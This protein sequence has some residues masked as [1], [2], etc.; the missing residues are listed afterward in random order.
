MKSNSPKRKHEI[1]YIATIRFPTEKAHGLQIAKMCEAF[2]KSGANVSLLIPNRT[3]P[4]EMK[5]ATPFSY[6]S[7]KDKYTIIKLACVDLL[8]TSK[9]SLKYL[10]YLLLK[11]SFFLSLMFYLRTKKNKKTIV[12]TREII[13][14][15]LVRM[16]GY[17][18]IFLEIHDWPQ[19]MAGDFISKKLLKRVNGIVCVSPQLKKRVIISN[20]INNNHILLSPNAIDKIFLKTHKKSE[21]RKI[22]KLPLNKNIVMY[23][24]GLYRSKGINTF[25]K[26]SDFFKNQ[27][28]LFVVVGGSYVEV[29]EKSIIHRIKQKPN[30]VHF[31][32]QKHNKMP[33]FLSAA[34]ILVIPNSEKIKA[35]AYKEYT[36]PLK[37]YEFMSAGRP[38]ILSKVTALK[39]I[40]KN[41]HNT[42]FFKPDSAEDLANKIK[43]LF[44]NK[45]LQRSLSKNAK[46]VVGKYSWEVRANNIL[47]FIE[48]NL[49]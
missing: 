21:S 4:T 22:I 10:S 9:Q 34:D 47:K 32:H 37:F 44:H 5:M 27:N 45:K 26:S 8:I 17:K 13:F 36:W 42:I 11:A 31:P 33:L 1:I 43:L 39:N 29:K 20:S 24:G 16:L 2:V 35:K 25:I 23:A 30:I 41:M 18:N 48:L 38:V 40:S 15:P 12:Y 14:I 28:I 7:I 6:Y 46:R 49:I 3:Q 19:S